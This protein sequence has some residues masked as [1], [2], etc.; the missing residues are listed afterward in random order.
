MKKVLVALRKNGEEVMSLYK[1]QSWL[2]VGA[3]VGTIYDQNHNDNHRNSMASQSLLLELEEGDRVQAC[4]NIL[5]IDHQQQE[6]AN[7][8]PSAKKSQ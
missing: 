8:I 5:S 6:Q 3:Q 4:P 7:M 1:R 2:K